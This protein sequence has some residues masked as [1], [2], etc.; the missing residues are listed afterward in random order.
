MYFYIELYCFQDIDTD[1]STAMYTL[2]GWQ[3]QSPR[4]TGASHEVGNTPDS[5]NA[6]RYGTRDGDRVVRWVIGR[7]AGT[8]HVSVE[9]A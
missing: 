5:H 6:L 3:V 1:N 2:S 4:M 8:R 7:D 9:Y